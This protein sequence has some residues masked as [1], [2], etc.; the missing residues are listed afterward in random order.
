LTQ[1]K[2]F[3]L[4]NGP[5]VGLYNEGVIVFP[6]YTF[7]RTDKDHKTSVL[8]YSKDHG[9]TW[10]LSNE[11]GDYNVE[12]QIASLTR[13]RIMANMRRQHGQEYRQ[14]AITSDLGKTWSELL[15]IQ[16]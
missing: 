8:V 4:Y 15:M 5:G 3:W 9:K 6:M 1:G 7:E 16:P 12:P 10:L 13:G 14:V 2:K 11:V